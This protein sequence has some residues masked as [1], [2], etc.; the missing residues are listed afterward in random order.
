MK[1]PFDASLFVDIRK[2]MGSK[3]FDQFN[4]LVIRKSEVLKPKRKRIIKGGKY[5]HKGGGPGGKGATTGKKG[6]SGN[7]RIPN[8]GKLKLD[9]SIADQYVT[10]PNDL[11][12]VNRVK[13]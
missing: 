5:D 1:L 13:E 11:K 12:L 9:A 10:A 8:Q 6:A 3:E 4:D 7:K 2:R